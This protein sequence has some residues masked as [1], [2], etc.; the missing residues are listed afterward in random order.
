ML[1]ATTNGLADDLGG[2]LGPHER[3]G[4]LI[5]MLDVGGDMPDELFDRDERTTAHRLA[6]QDAEPRFDHVEPGGPGWGEVEAHVRVLFQP[7]T[8]LGGG[9]GG[10][11]IQD[12]VEIGRASCRERGWTSVVAGGLKEKNGRIADRG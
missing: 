12:H 11:V 7:M 8:H 5:P 3:R 2:G 6:G 1:M 4:V 9:M 10:G